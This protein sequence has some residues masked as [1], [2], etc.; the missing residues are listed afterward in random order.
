MK[1]SYNERMQKETKHIK[2]MRKKMVNFDF[3]I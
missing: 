2:I 3:N 1:F